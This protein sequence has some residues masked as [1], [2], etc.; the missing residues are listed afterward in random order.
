MRSN[1]S[2]LGALALAALIAAAGCKK[3]SERAAE[4]RPETGAPTVPPASE[5]LP[6]PMPN[7]GAAQVGAAPPAGET[8]DVHPF[9]PVAGQGN[10]R[11]NLVVRPDAVHPDSLEL[12]ARLDGLAPGAH[13]WHI[14]AAPCGQQDAP[15]LVPLSPAGGRPGAGRDLR[16][17]RKGT[18]YDSVSVPAAPLRTGRPPAGASVR[19]HARAGADHGPTVACASL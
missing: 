18:V 11:G 2:V 7:E 15:V 19:V 5:P 3:E 6:A 13:A 1:Q 4:V 17:D 10:A 16:A 14:Y 9:Q 12:V 8:G